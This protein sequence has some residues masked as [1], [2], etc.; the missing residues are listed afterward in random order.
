MNK[1]DN[2]TAVD[3]F[4]PY[5]VNQGRLLD[6]YA[7]LNG[8]Y[9]EYSEIT[10]A[11]SNENSKSGK[12]EVS[13]NVGFKLFNFGS[14]GSG[15]IDNTSQ[16]STSST[17]KKVQT[18]TS[19]LSIV[20][21]ELSRRRYLCDIFKSKPGQFVCLPVILSINSVKSLLTEIS[22]LASLHSTISKATGAASDQKINKK[23]VDNALNSIRLLF[24]GE[25]VIYESD[26]FA[27]V[28]SITDS[29][30]YQSTRADIIATELNCLA[31]V[32]RVYPEGT[33][34]MKNTLFSK[35]KGEDVKK[36]FFDLL[37]ATLS[38]K[39]TFEFEAVAVPCIKGKPVYELEIIA[40]YQ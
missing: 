13:S 34:L 21:S 31:Q 37:T 36:K 2:M 1:T 3:L 12:A 27:I 38:D 8:G 6:I 39:N 23:E 35:M 14:N 16:Q 18:V 33:E 26:S 20:K 32:K 19:V 5:Y 24:N 15:A 10:S 40:L 25:E 17:E 30:L 7:I 22:D 11:V 4:F 28:G 29:N 9:S